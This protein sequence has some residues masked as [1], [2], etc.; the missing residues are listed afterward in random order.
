MSTWQQFRMSFKL[1][2]FHLYTISSFLNH[3]PEEILDPDKLEDTLASLPP[4]SN[5]S[6]TIT[7]THSTRHAHAHI[8]SVSKSFVHK[9]NQQLQ[10]LKH[11]LK[12][13]AQLQQQKKQRHSFA[14]YTTGVF[15]IRLLACVL[16]V[17]GC[18]PWWVMAVTLVQFFWSPLSFFS[19]MANFMA[20]A[21][22]L[23]L[24][25]T[26]L[27]LGLHCVFHTLFRLVQYLYIN[28]SLQLALHSLQD[29]FRLKISWGFI[30]MFFLLDQL[31]CL[32]LCFGKISSVGKTEVISWKRLWQSFWYGGLNCKTYQVL[33]LLILYSQHHQPQ[34]Q[35]QNHELDHHGGDAYLVSS[36]SSSSTGINLLPCLFDALMGGAISKGLASFLQP[37][38]GSWSVGFYSAHRLAHLPLVYEQAHKQ[39]HY[40]HGTTAFDAHI[41]GSGLG[42]EWF[43]VWYEILLGL[44]GLPPLFLSYDMLVV[45]WTSKLAHTFKQDNEGGINFH[46]WHHKLH[47]RNFGIYNCL[48]DLLFDTCGGPTSEAQH[49]Q[50]HGVWIIERKET[51]QVI[52]L[53]IKKNSAATPELQHRLERLYRPPGFLRLVASIR[54]TW[55]WNK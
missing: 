33:I 14:H 28:K 51:Q 38:L 32:A 44:M 31:V 45:S 9:W 41:Y 1:L 55:I 50:D 35:Q 6:S 46:A 15:G 11:D 13:L 24:P 7:T 54:R 8:I 17:L 49:R 5:S 37:R 10:T 21:S 40:L 22:R 2:N 26:L 3:I 42:E 53:E 52:Q 47:T 20:L 39:H 18:P 36:S 30:I 48:L 29:L 34:Q 4:R 19:S 12:G 16:A 23:F 27:A 25:H 43:M